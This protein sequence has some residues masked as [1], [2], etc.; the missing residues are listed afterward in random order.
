VRVLAERYGDSAVRIQSID[1]GWFS[2][3]A[4]SWVLTTDNKAFLENRA[5]AVEATPWAAGEQLARPWTDDFSSLWGPLKQRNAQA[6]NKWL[7]TPND[8]LFVYDVAQMIDESV[9]DRIRELT[10]ALYWDSEPRVPVLVITAKSME[11]GSSTTAEKVN[12][13]HFTLGLDRFRPELDVLIL[14][15]KEQKRIE[16]RVG[17][18]WPPEV[19]SYLQQRL[20]RTMSETV[21]TQGLSAALLLTVRSIKQFVRD[22]HLD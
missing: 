14:V 7:G 21:R 18:S 13:L 16:I 19:R 4:A 17:N 2:V 3:K 15:V 11:M 1:E 10:R 12:Q 20:Q 9:E 8:G 22:V 5:L 6:R